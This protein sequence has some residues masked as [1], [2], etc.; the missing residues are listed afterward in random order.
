MEA[1]NCGSKII[2][3]NQRNCWERNDVGTSW[4]VEWYWRGGRMRHIA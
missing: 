2:F 4:V 3:G 1:V